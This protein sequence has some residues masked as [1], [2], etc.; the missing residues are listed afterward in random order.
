MLKRINVKQRKLRGI[1]VQTDDMDL[2]EN[3]TLDN[4]SFEWGECNYRIAQDKV[5]AVTD[6]TF[7]IKS[8]VID[9]LRYPRMIDM[10]GYKHFDGSQ[11]ADVESELPYFLF[12]DIVDEAK[13][14]YAGAQP[15]ADIQKAVAKMTNNE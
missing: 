4:S 13:F 7:G 8:G 15:E 2:I 12:P 5:R 11:S 3:S 10:K 1:R 9:Y 14:I 6:G